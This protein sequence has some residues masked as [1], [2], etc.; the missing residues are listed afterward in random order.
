[1]LKTL[2]KAV[3]EANLRL[4]RAG[5]VTLTWGNVSGIDRERGLVVIKPSGI[6]YESMT[7]EDMV[8]VDLHGS[9]VEGKYKPSSD[10]ATHLR[11][12]E[13]FPEIGGVAHTHS[14]F[15]TSFAQAGKGIAA[16]GTTHADFF[17]GEVPCTR[18][19]SNEEINGEYEW[20]TGNVI[21]ETFLSLSVSPVS[22]PA[23][24][25]N[26]HGPFTWGASANEAVDNSVVLEEVAKMALRC[27]NLTPGLAQV[28]R[29]L[30]DKHYLRKHGTHAYYGQN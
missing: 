24:L 20:E 9:V 6:G 12:Y 5:L 3:C 16:F 15:A 19:L 4:P 2:R 8:V 1:M 26:R 17:H 10:T 27:M 11:L 30:L 29:A 14:S 13:A 18:E 28:N 21:V 22:V 23:V 25:V 7:F